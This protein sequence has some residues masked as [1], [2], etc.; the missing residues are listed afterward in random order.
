MQQW[1]KDELR[2]MTERSD[3]CR[4]STIFPNKK[5]STD[6]NGVKQEYYRIV[7]LFFNIN[8]FLNLITKPILTIENIRIVITR[9]RDFTNMDL[10]QLFFQNYLKKD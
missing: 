7:K 2:R 4:W 9:S 8:G 6:K 10:E 5:P 3:S 1:M